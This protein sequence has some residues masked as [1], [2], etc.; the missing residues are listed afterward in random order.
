MTGK[1]RKIHSIREKQLEI[2]CYWDSIWQEY[3]LR[4]Y[5]KGV[6]QEER[7]YYTDDKEDALYTM[8]DMFARTCKE[9]NFEKRFGLDV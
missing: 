8:K 6:L 4:V 7:T 5:I 1:R 3:Q 9:L 2:K